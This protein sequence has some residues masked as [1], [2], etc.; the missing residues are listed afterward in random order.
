MKP[1]SQRQDFWG[2]GGVVWRVLDRPCSPASKQTMKTKTTSKV[3]TYGNYR[4]AREAIIAVYWLCPHCMKST[5]LND[6]YTSTIRMLQESCW[7]FEN[8]FSKLL[9]L[10]LMQNR[11]WR[12]WAWPPF[13]FPSS[14]SCVLLLPSCQLPAHTHTHTHTHVHNS[15]VQSAQRILSASFSWES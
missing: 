1:G 7:P 10:L 9:R 8:V 4:H 5:I 3:S 14:A 15:Q 2:T 6:W 12:A 13:P 11:P